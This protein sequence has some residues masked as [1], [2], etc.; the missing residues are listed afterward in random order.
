MLL[1]PPRAN[2][3]HNIIII[4]KIKTIIKSVSSNRQRRIRKCNK[5]V[6]SGEENAIYLVKIAG[7]AR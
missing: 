1:N 5:L 7:D 2:L 6:V 4:T 3:N